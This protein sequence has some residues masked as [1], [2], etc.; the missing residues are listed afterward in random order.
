MRDWPTPTP[1]PPHTRFLSP[2]HPRRR[3]SW[4]KAQLEKA[5]DEGLTHTNPYVT[6]AV[7]LFSCLPTAIL[8]VAAVTS[9]QWGDSFWDGDK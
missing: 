7:G 2:P 8:G 3:Y 5:R 6:A 4:N 1:M 9:T